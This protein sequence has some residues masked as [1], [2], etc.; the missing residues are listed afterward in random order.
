MADEPYSVTAAAVAAGESGVNNPNDT[1]YTKL[2]DEQVSNIVGGVSSW[3]SSFSQQSQQFI[4][5]T[6][7]HIEE[8]GGIY[9]AARNEIAR[10]EKEIEK[11]AT[12]RDAE[13]DAQPSFEAFSN[14][15]WHSLQGLA[16]IPQ[17]QKLREQVA[18]GLPQTA[19][20][21]QQAITSLPAYR[22]V[23]AL[24]TKYLGAGEEFAKDVG[25]DIRSTLNSIVSFAPANNPS[26]L[27]GRPVD[28]EASFNADD[29]IGQDEPGASS[30]PSRSD[31]ST[32]T[33]AASASAPL[34]SG[35]PGAAS[36]AGVSAAGVGAASVGAAGVGAT[37]APS[38]DGTPFVPAATP[39]DTTLADDD[40]SWDDDDEDTAAVETS[41]VPIS[42]TTTHA[43][44][45][46][47]STQP[48]A[49]GDSDWE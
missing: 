43:T 38:A 3:W 13:G 36:S 46:P 2:V 41:T 26:V 33:A 18:N 5:S 7:K 8:Q 45:V 29:Y 11:V 27:D 22:E 9:S 19:D 12:P 6:Q 48:A 10:I 47:A 35:A 40:F 25:R 28:I 39:A 23:E 20:D 42:A 17:V 30:A 16:H 32:S 14:N 21:A 15:V 49:D 37:G 4:S 31:A 1:N 24:A 44:Q 34:A